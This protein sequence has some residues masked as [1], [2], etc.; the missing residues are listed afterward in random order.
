MLWA[1]FTVSQLLIIWSAN[2]PE[3]IPFYLERLHGAVVRRSAW[4]VLFGHFAL[5]FLLLL[6]RDIKR[7]PRRVSWVALFIL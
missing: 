2:L 4:P 7:N 5:P 3:E 1:Y 6:S